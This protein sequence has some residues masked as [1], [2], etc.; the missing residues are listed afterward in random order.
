MPPQFTPLALSCAPCSRQCV[1]GLLLKIEQPKYPIMNPGRYMCRKHFFALNM[2]AIC[3]A[4][5]RIL[6][7]NIAM[8]GSTGEDWPFVACLRGRFNLL[9]VVLI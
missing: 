7:Y 8:P 1:L 6:W 3:A 9:A 2:Q 4:D 5:G